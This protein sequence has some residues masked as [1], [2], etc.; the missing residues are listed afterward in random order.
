MK[1]R[2]KK[3]S[4]LLCRLL[5]IGGVA[6]FIDYVVLSVARACGLELWA[7]SS[8][9]F[10]IGTLI[11]Y[12]WSSA[13]AFGHMADRGNPVVELIAFFC[14]G[15]IGLLLNNWIILTLVQVDGVGLLGAKLA[16]IFSVFT[17]NTSARIAT[18]VVLSRARR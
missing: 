6:S 12:F 7:S 18:M 17:W 4:N 9:G 13:W 10:V 5:V 11:V 8:L 16:A 2:L 15:L 3:Y 1:S 14:V